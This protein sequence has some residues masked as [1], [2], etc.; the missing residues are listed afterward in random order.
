[1]SA[2]TK[3]GESGTTAQMTSAGTSVMTGAARNRNLLERA[4]TMISLQEPEIAQDGQVEERHA[5]RAEPQ[6]HVAEDLALGERHHRDG[7]DERCHDHE[8]PEH[9]GADLGGDRREA[10]VRNQPALQCRE[11]AQYTAAGAWPSA[12][13]CKA[14]ARRRMASI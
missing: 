6:L 9:D 14:G 1:M 11:H 12:V 4:G 5:V 7:H 8:Y 13:F 10:P 2:S 3:S